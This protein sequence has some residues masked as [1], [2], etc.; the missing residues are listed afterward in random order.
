MPTAT[1]STGCRDAYRAAGREDEW[2]AYHKELL[3]K[4]QRKYKLRPMLEQL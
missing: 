2:Q 4:H 3:D 1:P